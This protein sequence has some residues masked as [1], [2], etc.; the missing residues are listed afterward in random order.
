MFKRLKSLAKRVW[1]VCTDWITDPGLDLL[2]GEMFANGAAVTVVG[3][4]AAFAAAAGGFYF[5]AA[6]IGTA[7][8]CDLIC[9]FHT[10]KVFIMQMRIQTAMMNF[11]MHS[12]FGNATAA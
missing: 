12:P 2:L 6:I 9:K 3:A 1:H 7:V 11:A 5:V 10:A 8:I 4:A